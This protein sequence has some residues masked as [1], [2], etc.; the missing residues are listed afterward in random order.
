MYERLGIGL[1]IGGILTELPL[2]LNNSQAYVR[3]LS[4]SGQVL[5]RFWP[6]FGQVYVRILSGFGQVLVRF[7]PDFGQVYVRF[8]SG[9]GQVLVRFWPDF[10]QVYVRFLSGSGQ[11]AC[12]I[13][14]ALSGAVLSGHLN[15]RHWPL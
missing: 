7:W 5:V 15:N 12:Y 6:D 4:G 11:V 1:G 9:S 10:G 3:F 13:R 2:T 8:L 14:P